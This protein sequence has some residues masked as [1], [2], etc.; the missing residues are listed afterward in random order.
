[1]RKGNVCCMLWLVD[2]HIKNRLN[3]S[4]ADEANDFALAA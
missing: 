4:N 3:F 1:M 2:G